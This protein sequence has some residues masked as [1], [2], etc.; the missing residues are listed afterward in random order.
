MKTAKQ[1]S[2]PIFWSVRG[3]AKIPTLRMLVNP[4]NLDF[5][6]TPLIN[7]TRTLGGFIQEFWGEQLT[8]LSA[9]GKTAM[10]ISS[11]KGLTNKDSRTTEAYQ[12]FMSLL[13]IYKNNGKGYFTKFEDSASRANSTKISSFGNIIMNYDNKQYDGY[14]ESFNYTEDALLPFNLEY[15]FNFKI[16]KIFGQKEL[17]YGRI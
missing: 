9:S 11:E 10:F 1:V 3:E 4:A 6:Y 13:N 16:I 7:E 15:S 17:N 12:Y 8:T 5:T 14:F 2:V